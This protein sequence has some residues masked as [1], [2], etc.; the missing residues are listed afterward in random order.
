MAVGTKHHVHLHKAISFVLSF[1]INLLLELL[2]AA[3]VAVVVVAKQLPNN[4]STTIMSFLITILAVAMLLILKMI[5]TNRTLLNSSNL[6]QT[7]VNII[8]LH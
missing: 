8:F 3:V 2:G 4:R 6:I 1:I 5:K 7:Q